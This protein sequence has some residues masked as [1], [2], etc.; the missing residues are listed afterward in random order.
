M[1]NDDPWATLRMKQSVDGFARITIDPESMNGQ[2]CIR[3]M[4][5]TVR[6][7]LEMLP[8]YPD[9]ASLIKDYPE[10]EPEDIVEALR[11][12]AQSL[13]DQVLV[14]RAA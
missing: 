12:A 8:G 1:I 3:G 11:F 2:P 4:R 14:H 13:D 6:R 7:V 5:V 10:L 9:W